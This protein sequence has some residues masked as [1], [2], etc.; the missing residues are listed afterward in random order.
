MLDEDIAD[1]YF[2]FTWS[3]SWTIMLSSRWRS[4]RWCSWVLIFKLERRAFIEKK[5]S[6]YLR[7]TLRTNFEDH[8]RGLSDYAKWLFYQ[9]RW[10]KNRSSKKTDEGVFTPITLIVDRRRDIQNRKFFFLF[11]S[12]SILSRWNLC[13]NMGVNIY[14]SDLVKPNTLKY[15]ITN[16]EDGES[17]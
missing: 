10:T 12:S 3:K 1:S 17:L 16:F 9:C 5:M 8:E 14:C 7:Q 2:L 15:I 13:S 11:I 6:S 4:W